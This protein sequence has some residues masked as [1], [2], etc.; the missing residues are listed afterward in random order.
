MAFSLINIPTATIITGHDQTLKAHRLLG[1]KE[2]ATSFKRKALCVP[3]DLSRAAN[4]SFVVCAEA[5]NSNVSKGG[6]L[7]IEDDD[8]LATQPRIGRRTF[9][10]DFVFGA[11][12]AAYQVATTLS[13]LRLNCEN[14]AII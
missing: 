14:K 5:Q 11:A 12:T 2:I 10:P 13:F 8:V 9:P 3:P 7:T 1:N 6:V 4:R